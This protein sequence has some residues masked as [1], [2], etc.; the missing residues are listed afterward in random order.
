[1]SADKVVLLDFWVSSFAL[2]VKIALLEKNIEF[3][4]LHEDLL[5]NK[6]ELLLRSN[7]I[8]KKVPV[9]LP[10]NKP[11]CES[12]IIMNYIEE[13]WL[14]PALLPKCPYERSVIRFWADFVDKKLF[15]GGRSTWMSKGEA[16]E[17]AKIEFIEILKQLEGFLGEKN[18]FNGDSFGFLDIVIFP[19]TSW[20]P[21]YEQCGGFKVDDECPNL[22]TWIK[23]CMER[24][25]V[26]KVLPD[27]V[28]VYEFVSMMRKMH[29]LE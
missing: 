21:A 28:K 2:R 26:S 9:L 15:E 19:M 29:G 3:E 23:R 8:H 24:E 4:V 13:K 5:G 17:T 16:L 20:F 11:I 1:M 25:S 10:D 14:S 6:S 12:L 18:F 22:A 27:P 7:P